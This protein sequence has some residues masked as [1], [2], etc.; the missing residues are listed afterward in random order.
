MHNFTYLTWNSTPFWLR[1]NVRSL[2]DLFT[3]LMVECFSIDS[4]LIACTYRYRL[5][6]ATSL[7]FLL[8]KWMSLMNEDDDWWFCWHANDKSQCTCPL[9]FF[10][11]HNALTLLVHALFRWKKLQDVCIDFFSFE[12]TTTKL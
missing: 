4:N 7:L 3:K 9:I 2:I 10:S 11:Y 5:Q 1:G 8:M 12:C 6:I